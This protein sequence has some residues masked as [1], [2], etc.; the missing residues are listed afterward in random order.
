MS[1]ALSIRHPAAGP[2]PACLA[3]SSSAAVLKLKARH[4]ALPPGTAIPAQ[5]ITCAGGELPISFKLN[6]KP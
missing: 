6:L 2:V 1:S 5:A 3:A 4:Y